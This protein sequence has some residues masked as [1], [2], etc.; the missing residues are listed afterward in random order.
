MGILIYR[1]SEAASEAAAILV[2]AQIIQKP[3]SVL[4]FAS[5]TTP[6]KVYANLMN[7]TEKGLL[8]WADAIC[9][10]PM[11]YIGVPADDKRSIARH[12]AK[13]L[14]ARINLRR[15]NLCV[16]NGAA[17]DM[18]Q[19]CIAYEDAILKHGGI[20]LQLLS[21]GLGGQ[22]IG[23]GTN[24][25]FSAMTQ[26]VSGSRQ[27]LQEC[28]NP[29]IPLGEMPMEIVS[30]G[31]GTIMAARKII[32]LAFGEEKADI[33]NRIING[34]I[35]PEVPASVLQI[36]NEVTYILDEAAAKEL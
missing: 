15:G 35:T 9:V 14:Y 16:L 4:A 23:N 29:D 7:M 21:V 13:S 26:T 8:D 36:H 19:E 6:Q 2:A 5:G 3:D 1:D 34:P 30:M 25:E 20:D 27:M 22:L 33:V 11:E 17:K 32:F 28:G 18:E 24:T 10:N 31:I 12:M